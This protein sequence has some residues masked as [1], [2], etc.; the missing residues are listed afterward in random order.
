MPT[1]VVDASG[2][3][4]VL[5]LVCAPVNVNVVVEVAPDVL[6]PIFLVASVL[7]TKKFVLFCNDLFDNV[8]LV[9][10]PTIVSVDVGK[11]NVP[12]LTIVEIIGAV[13]VLL[14]R[15]SVVALPT[16]VSVASG[17]VKI[18]FDV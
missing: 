7:S 2:N 16:R 3:V 4:I 15:V 12:V 1:N 14:V 11:V 18:L 10:L 9:A 13:K 8:S 17:N 6:N 5:L